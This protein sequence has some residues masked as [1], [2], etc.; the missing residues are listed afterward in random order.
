MGTLNLRIFLKENTWLSVSAVGHQKGYS[1]V[2]EA[3]PEKNS[4]E[5]KT[6]ELIPQTKNLTEVTVTSKKPL[7]EQKSIAPL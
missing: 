1:E 4:I 2:F 7:I 6:I 3:T 5:L